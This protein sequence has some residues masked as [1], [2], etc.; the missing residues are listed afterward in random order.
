MAHLHLNHL[1][2]ELSFV[3]NFLLAFTR[4]NSTHQRSARLPVLLCSIDF[5]IR[6]V[7]LTSHG[8]DPAEKQFALLFEEVL[9]QHCKHFL[10]EGLRRL[11]YVA[12]KV[13]CFCDRFA[14]E[15]RLPFGI[16]GT[17]VAMDLVVGAI[18]WQIVVRVC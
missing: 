9:L 7:E 14:D 4:D 17:S 2:L 18:V 12:D 6:H 10:A 11:G 13:C 8:E 1:H 16:Y 15:R 5:V 3:F